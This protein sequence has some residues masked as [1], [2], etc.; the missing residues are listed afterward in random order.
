MVTIRKEVFVPGEYY[1]VFSRTIINTPEFQN[2]SSARRLLM[3]FLI[4]NSTKS[5]DGFQFLRNNKDATLKDIK[6]NHEFYPE[7]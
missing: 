2:N 3:A 5:S 6:W 7:M 1:H 4:A